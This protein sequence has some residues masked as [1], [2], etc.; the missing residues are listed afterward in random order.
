MTDF[1]ESHG[2]LLKADVDALVNTVNTVGVMGKGIAL[3][4]KKAFG[5]NFKAYQRACRRGEVQIGRMHVFDNGQLVS[6]RWIINFPTKR[7]WRSPSRLSDIAAGLEAL[8]AEIIRLGIAS[9]AVPPLG[10]GNGGLA[11]AD[12]RPLIEKHL[13]GLGVEVHVY[14]P[15]GAPAAADMRDATAKP[16]WTPGRAALVLLVDRIAAR[17]LEGGASLVGVQKLMYFLQE[18]GEPLR[19]NFQR[20]RYGPYA[21]NLRHVLKAVDGHF[22]QGYGDGSAKVF[23][24]EPLRAVPEAV[25]EAADLIIGEPTGDRVEEVLGLVEGFESS[26]ALELLA[27]VHWIA[28]RESAGGDTDDIIDKVRGWSERKRG[29]FSNKHVTAAHEHLRAHGWL[30]A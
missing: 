20:G 13:D 11:W 10:C 19:L 12:V 18:A 27:T 8:R 1:V 5:A 21:D 30:A 22:L 6:P 24:A 26:Y 28:H 2:N 15:E 4:F 9:V 7:H 25:D 16:N 23:E 3:Q 14:A 17:T 29:M